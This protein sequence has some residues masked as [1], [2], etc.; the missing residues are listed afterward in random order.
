MGTQKKAQALCLKTKSKKHY[1]QQ[2]NTCFDTKNKTHNPAYPEQ[3]LNERAKHSLILQVTLKT[4]CCAEI[5]PSHR[6]FESDIIVKRLNPTV[7]FKKMFGFQMNPS[8]C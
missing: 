4:V 3:G 7:Y 2:N 5:E 1:H 8:Q 6:E